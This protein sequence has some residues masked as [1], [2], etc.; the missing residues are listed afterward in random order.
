[1]QPEDRDP[2][3]LW[4]KLQAASE[5]DSMLEDYDMTALLADR[6]MLRALERG[7][8]IDIQNTI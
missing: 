6:V 5:F 8:D 2:A 3:Y 1:M 7:I 4:D